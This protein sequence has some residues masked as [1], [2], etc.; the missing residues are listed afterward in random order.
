MATL[1]NHCQAKPILQP[2]PEL[3]RSKPYINLSEIQL[4]L[5]DHNSRPM[6]LIGGGHLLAILVIVYQTKSF[7]KLETTFDRRK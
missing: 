1:V 5:S 3:N 7:F 6:Q 4:K 2:E